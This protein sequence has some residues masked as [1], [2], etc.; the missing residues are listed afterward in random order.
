MSV[1]KTLGNVLNAAHSVV[2][3]GWSEVGDGMGGGGGV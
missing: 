2:K 1:K 3:L